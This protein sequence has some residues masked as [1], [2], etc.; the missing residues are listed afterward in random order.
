V[1]LAK[2]DNHVESGLSKLL[3]QFKEKPRL[4]A[5][6]KSYLLQVQEVED[7]VWELLICRLIDDAEGQWLTWLGKIVGQPRREGTDDR[8]R[9]LVRAR[10]AVNKSHGTGDELLGIASL[11]LGEDV[12]FTMTEYFPC[13]IV[14]QI[15]DPIDFIPTFELE[16]LDEAAL[17]GVRVDVHFSAEDPDDWF[18]FGAGPGWG[19]GHWIGN[20]SYHTA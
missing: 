12:D 6:I 11:L 13:S 4:A 16:M 19:V 9:V 20:V 14:F 7:A 1:T 15:D 3:E 8:Y 2:I 5:W 17:A 18:M 10:I